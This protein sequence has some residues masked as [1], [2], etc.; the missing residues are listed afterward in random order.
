MNMEFAYTVETDKSFDKVAAAVEENTAKN[1]FRVLAVHDVQAT[2]AEK[3]FQRN[4]LKII[5]VCNAKFA[6]EALAKNPEVALF[7]PCRIAVYGEG[8][9]TIVKLGRPSMIATMMPNA[10][11]NDLANGV[12]ATLKKVIE[13]SI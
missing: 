9:K 7:M 11:L 12:E 10:G 1:M 5:E 13:E 3:G 4:P 8:K 2:L 6:H